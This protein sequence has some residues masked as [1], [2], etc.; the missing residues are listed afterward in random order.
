MGQ[1]SGEPGTDRAALTSA[2]QAQ[3]CDPSNKALVPFPRVLENLSNQLQWTE[4]LGNAFLAQQAD[5]MAAVQSLRRQAMATGNFKQD[6]AM[7]LRNSSAESRAN[8]VLGDVF[9]F[10]YEVTHT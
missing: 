3:S 1:N 6:P 9:R 5:L 8:S 10:K 7:P 2:L 4:Q